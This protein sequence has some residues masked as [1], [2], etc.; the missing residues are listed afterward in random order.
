MAD[1]EHKLLLWAAVGA[2]GVAAATGAYWAAKKALDVY[3]PYQYH[4]RP[5]TVSGWLAH[6]LDDYSQRRRSRRP[7]RVYM[8]GCFDMMHY[9]HANALRQVSSEKK[10]SVSR[11]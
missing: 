11:S 3:V 4:Y 8:D 2:G 9:G 5:G 10:R 7:V 1:K 6:I